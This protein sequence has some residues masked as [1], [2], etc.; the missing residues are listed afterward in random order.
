MA[1]IEKSPRL[2]PP[3]PNPLPRGERGIG[4]SGGEGNWRSGGEGG[5]RMNGDKYFIESLDKA[6]RVAEVLLGGRERR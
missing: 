5:E 2:L 1:V 6:M 3:H 4:G